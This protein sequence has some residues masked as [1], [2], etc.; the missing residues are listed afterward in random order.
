MISS[1]KHR[2][3]Q[4]GCGFGVSDEKMAA[5][6]LQALRFPVD[7]V[8]VDGGGDVFVAT[9]A[10]VFLDQ[11]IKLDLDRIGIPTGREIKR[12]ARSRCWLSRRFCRGCYAACG[13][14]CS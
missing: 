7:D 3:G 9:A 14:R 5:G 11:V 4:R 6:A 8:A 12:S 13:S 2:L 1:Y 10:G